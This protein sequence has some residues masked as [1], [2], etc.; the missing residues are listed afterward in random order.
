MAIPQNTNEQIY[1]VLVIGA[2]LSGVYS[3]YKIRKEFPTWNVKCLE[4]GGD[5]GGVWY[6]NSYPGCRIDTESLSY[7]YSFDKELLEEWSW[8]DQFATQTDTYQYIKRVAEKHDLH[9]DMFFHT[10]IAS[11]Q[12]NGK[13]SIWTFTDEEGRQYRT[14][15][16][17]SCLGFLSSPT[18]PNIPGIQDFVGDAFHTSRWPAKLDH[19]RDFAGKRI[20]VIGTGATGIQCITAISKEPSIKSLTV[21][22]RTANW[23]APLRNSGITSEQ[24]DS[25]K[26]NYDNLFQQCAETPSGFL[27]AADPRKSLE[28]SPEERLALWEKLNNAPGFGKWMGVFSDTYTSREA[29]DMYSKFIADKIRGRVLDPDIAE[30]LIP[31]NHGFGTRRV[32]LESG[33]FE[34]FNKPNVHLVDLQKTPAETV[35]A[36][37]IRTA[38]GADHDLDVLI[39]ATGFD[40]IT[41][42]YHAINWQAKDGRR[43]TSSPGSKHADKAIWPEQRP[44]TFLGLMAP[45]MPNNFMV[46]GPHQPF[47]NATR[48]I[49]HAVDFICDLLQHCKQNDI[50]VVE[51]TEEA[52]DAWTEHVVV[53]SKAAVLVNE[54]DSWITGVN[55][56]VDGKTV[57]SVVRYSGSAIDYRRRCKECRDTGYSGLIFSK[58]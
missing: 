55:K 47:G 49:E 7:C 46:L 27:H 1:D 17:V 56:N 26:V 8:K 2:G 24:M 37:G 9:K 34:A 39:F 41:G 35:T 38:D 50:A 13:N 6:W 30:S 52:V 57:R 4:A 29:N 15:F 16:F 54:V 58:T 43:L 21:F 12:W 18:L 14:R 44:Q 31:K 3:L 5:V 42:A 51:P 53:C 11:A 19:T 25:H 10:R 20:G 28:V 36:S 32:P 33:Y 22:Q 40:A 45:S 48:S 23:S